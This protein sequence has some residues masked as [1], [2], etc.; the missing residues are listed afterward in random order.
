MWSQIIIRSLFNEKKQGPNFH[1]WNAIKSQ[2]IEPYL[3]RMVAGGSEPVQTV[4]KLEFIVKNHTICDL[5]IHFLLLYGWIPHN[6]LYLHEY[7]WKALLTKYLNYSSCCTHVGTYEQRDTHTEI[8]SSW[9]SN[10]FCLQYELIS[11]LITFNFFL[12]QKRHPFSKLT[13]CVQRYI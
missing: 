4:A 10:N 6:T 13:S 11:N 5:Q 1:L 7:Q 8:N 12:N 2:K 9:H 3:R